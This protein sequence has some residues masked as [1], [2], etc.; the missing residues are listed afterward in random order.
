MMMMMKTGRVV[1]CCVALLLALTSVSAVERKLDSINDLKEINFGHS[2]PKHSILLLYWFANAVDIDWTN[3]MRLTF[4]PESRAYGSHHYANYEGLLDGLPWGNRYQY[5]TLGSLNQESPMQLPPYVVRPPASGYEGN[6]MD[7]IIVRIR[8]KTTGQQVPQMIDQVYITQHLNNQREYDPDHT[9]RITT[10]L[11][12]QIREFSGGQNHQQLVQLSNRFGSNADDSWLR[13]MRNTWAPNL[14]GLGLLLYIL[15]EERSSSH[16]H[17]NRQN[18]WALIL[19]V[20]FIVAC[21]I[22]FGNVNPK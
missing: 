4:D 19:F 11:L 7:R 6:N 20:I 21:F 16:Q 18:N 14:S 13:H 1:S 3:D 2:V 12:R 5:Y 17:N 8:D 22:I 10:N 9:Y 15:T